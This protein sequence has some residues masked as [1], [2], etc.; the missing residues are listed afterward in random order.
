MNIFLILLGILL[1]ALIILALY[2]ITQKKHTILRNFPIVG[3]FRYWLESIGPELRQYIITSSTS[4]RP[5]SR[6]ERRWVYASAKGENDMFGFGTDNDIEREGHPII[7]PAL[8]PLQAP[9]Y[10]SMG[11]PP[12]YRVPCAKVLG[13]ARGRARAFRPDSIINI[14]GMSYGALSPEAVHAMN[15]GAKIAGCLHNTG[16]GGLSRFHKQGGDLIFQIGTGYF[17]CRDDEGRFSLDK[18]IKLCQDNP[19]VKALE[20]K[21]S[22][23]AK[24]G[25]G[26]TLP[27]AKVSPEIAEARGVPVGVTNK[28][29]N[30]HTA[31]HDV[32]S[33]VDFIELL[34]QE[35]GLPVGVK[36]A[37]GELGPWQDLA[38]IMAEQRRGPD[39][40]TIDGGEGGTGA[41]PLVYTDHVAMPFFVGFS[42]V[43]RIFAER[44]IDHEVVWIGSGRL[45]LPYRATHAF[46][47]GCDMIH[48]ARE[49]MLSIGCIQAQRCHTNHCPAGV[50]TQ[51]AWLRR[52]LD[53]TLKSNRCSSYILALRRELMS[54]SRTCG[55]QHPGLLRLD[56][57]SIV[58]DRITTLSAQAAYEYEK[59]WGIPALGDQEEILRIMND[60]E[61]G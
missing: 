34:A 27:G 52:G 54:I 25:L 47:L 16:E 26:G 11:G 12:Q 10:D 33:M 4:E 19:Q 17:G 37:V 7:K 9:D 58:R 15:A 50:A 23:G 28:S 29:P 48:V 30:S 32:Q 20:I 21:L 59:D 38:E 51:N 61:Y 8:F 14:S 60:P 45:G 40:I 18:L 22:Q 42:S 24:P 39:F 44:G 13:Q 56:Q 6:N 5:F 53:P 3:H 36:S 1:L 55:V 49:A 43:Y 31:F 41:A 2:D 46:A 35:T 57:I